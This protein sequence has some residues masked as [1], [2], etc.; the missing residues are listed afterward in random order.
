MKKLPKTIKGKEYLALLCDGMAGDW[1]I[2]GVYA[3]M[4]EALKVK[5]QIRGCAGKHVIKK[6]SM[7][8]TLK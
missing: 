7:V 1:L 2:C 3:E 8:L 4:K 5:Q 6:C